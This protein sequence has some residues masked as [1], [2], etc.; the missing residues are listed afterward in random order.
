M[1]KSAQDFADVPILH[2]YLN[3]APLTNN[4]TKSDTTN[5]LVSVLQPGDL[6]LVLLDPVLT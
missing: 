6:G 3:F 1:L 2:R 5:F 4:G